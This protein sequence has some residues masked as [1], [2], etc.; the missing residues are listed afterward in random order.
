MFEYNKRNLAYF[1]CALLTA[2][3]NQKEGE[4]YILTNIADNPESVKAAR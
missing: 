2:F 3:G 1:V 4:K